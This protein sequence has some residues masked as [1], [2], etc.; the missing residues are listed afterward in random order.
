MNINRSAALTL[1]LVPW[2][3]ACAKYDQSL[4]VSDV[5][6]PQ[7]IVLRKAEGQS[8]IYRLSLKATGRLDGKATLTLMLNGKLYKIAKAS[9]KV[10][11]GWDGDWYADTAEIRYEPTDVTTGSITLRYSFHDM[12]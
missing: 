10:S 2:L 1:L 3:V 8:A 11:F 12:K 6:A 9:G 7:A 4:T 5:H